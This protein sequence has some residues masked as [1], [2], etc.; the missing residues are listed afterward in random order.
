MQALFHVDKNRSKHKLKVDMLK[1]PARPGA[2]RAATTR[3]LDER[4]TKPEND[5]T[6]H[7]G[8]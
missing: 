6:R 7:K 2:R 3:V 5:G 4:S 1:I 8:G